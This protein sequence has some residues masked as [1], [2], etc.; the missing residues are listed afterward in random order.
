MDFLAVAELF[1]TPTAELADLVLPA[2]MNLEFNDL[3]AYGVGGRLIPRSKVIEPPGEAW[4]DIKIMNELAKKLGLGQ[5]FWPDVDSA[6]DTILQPSGLTPQEVRQKGLFSG[7]PGYKKYERSGF[8]TPSTKVEIYSQ[9]LEEMGYSPLPVFR[10]PPEPT[11]EYP[12]LLTNGKPYVFFHSSLRNVP[13]LRKM[14][15]EPV[16]E[17]HPEAAAPLGIEE[18]DW[19]YIETE[20]G[21]IKQKATL[22]ARL[23]PRVVVAAADWFFPERGGEELYGWDESNLNI[24]TSGAPPYDPVVGAVQLRGVPCRVSK[25]L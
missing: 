18:G 25:E 9:Q 12:L 23:D 6:W 8:R 10:E 3:G 24:L 15:P 20:K 19:V 11:T 22:N 2:A 16:V 4:S 5:H 21:R 14:D 7:S 17:V 1:M 13:N